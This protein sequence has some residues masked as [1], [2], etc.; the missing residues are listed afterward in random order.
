MLH[1]LAKTIYKE[2][3]CPMLVTDVFKI[4][5]LEQYH[6]LNM[7]TGMYLLADAFALSLLGIALSRCSSFLHGPDTSLAGRSKD[8]CCKT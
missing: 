1:G 5:N 8:G 3:L 6:N 7:E 4:Q 2:K